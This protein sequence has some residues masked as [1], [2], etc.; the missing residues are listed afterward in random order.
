MDE[1]TGDDNLHLVDV[2]SPEEVE[3]HG[4]LTH[5]FKDVI[6]AARD[7]DEHARVGTYGAC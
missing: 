6:D 2:L 3:E 1:R 4:V 5:E 7:I